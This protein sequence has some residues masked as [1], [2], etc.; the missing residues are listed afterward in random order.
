MIKTG[1]IKALM[2][3][4]VKSIHDD[5]VM[6]DA[7]GSSVK[8]PND[9]VIINAG[10]ILPLE[11]L[12]ECGVEV[13]RY[14]GEERRKTS[15]TATVKHRRA[16]EEQLEEQKR[17]NFTRILTVVGVA[18]I[19]VLTFVGWQYYW[20]PLPLRLRSPMHAFLKP[21]GP[22]GHGVG[23]VATLFLISNFTYAVRKRWRR[24]KGT[25]SIRSWL[26][27]HMFVGFMS[28]LVILYHAAFQSKNVFA[29]ATYIGLL[30]VVGTGIIGRYIYGLVPVAGGKTM[31]YNELLTS[32]EQTLA[33]LRPL[34]GQTISNQTRHFVQWVAAPGKKGASVISVL[35][36]MP[37]N[38]LRLRFGLLALRNSLRGTG[39]YKECA[40][41]LK[42]IL[43]MKEQMRVYDSVKLLM[44]GWR[45][46][47]VVLSTVLV[48]LITIHIYISIYLGYRWIIK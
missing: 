40:Q 47:H 35:A 16:N 31:E 45:V 24:L 12:K 14:F 33:G 20:L 28:P 37:F 15:A 2:S 48:V 26:T 44:R 38:W 39:Q 41:Q 36:A 18:I 32:W 8:L 7:Q 30:I 1:R 25:K 42:R 6:I 4:E 17:R 5:H 10:G 22:W 11:F 34:L 29:T 46:F 9:Y 13:K 21:G 23:I 3:S 43:R 19:L 27:F